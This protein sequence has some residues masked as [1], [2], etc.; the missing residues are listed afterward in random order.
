M[1]KQL[2]IPASVGEL[3]DK[4]TILEIKQ[5]HATDSNKLKNIVTELSELGRLLTI[6]DPT[7]V[8]MMHELK[9][10]NQKIWDIEDAI[11]KKEHANEFDND[12][13]ELARAVYINNDLRAVIKR[14]I[15]TNTGSHIIEEK[16]Y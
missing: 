15:N 1:N 4:I 6:T 5:E 2:L 7:V 16:I 9:I 14:Q 11:R 13:I 8:A 10:V 3:I 12:F